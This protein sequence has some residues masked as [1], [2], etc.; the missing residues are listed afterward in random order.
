MDFELTLKMHG[1][2]VQINISLEFSWKNFKIIQLCNSVIFI[3]VVVVN[4][5]T[6]YQIGTTYITI[7]SKY[8]YITNYSID[9]Q[10]R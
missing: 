10:S 7:L 1:P 3:G 9:T 4:L 5:C 6:F 8:T 2:Y